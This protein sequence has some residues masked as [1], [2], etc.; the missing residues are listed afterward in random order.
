MCVTFE[1]ESLP[2]Y[3][4]TIKIIMLTEE[5]FALKKI[6]KKIGW[7]A[8]YM[9]GK[10]Y[11]ETPHGVCFNFAYVN[12]SPSRRGQEDHIVQFKS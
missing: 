10:G 5:T 6:F 2:S 9:Q 12:H 3:E 7:C 4:N 1:G 8:N 11:N